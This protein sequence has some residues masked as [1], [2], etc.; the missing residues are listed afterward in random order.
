MSL[1]NLTSSERSELEQLIS[2][3]WGEDNYGT[4]PNVS[5][6]ILLDATDP[7]KLGKALIE[8]ARDL[9]NMGDD[10]ET[11]KLLRYFAAKISGHKP[12][13][14]ANAAYMRKHRFDAEMQAYRKSQIDAQ[15]Q[16]SG[17]PIS[18]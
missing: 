1:S 8:R 4:G 6:S 15:R 7:V 18:K 3:A 9:E 11:P 16:K 14:E 17:R 12:S 13:I 10:P 2:L 5:M